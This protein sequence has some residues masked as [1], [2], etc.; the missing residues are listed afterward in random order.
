MEILTSHHDV[1]DDLRGG[2]LAIGNFDGVHRGHQAVLA[3]ALDA[4]K[5]AGVPAGVMSF[6]PHPLQV[7]R[8]D[9][10]L[11]RLTNTVQKTRLFAA[12]GLDI[13]AI[14]PFDKALYGLPGKDFIQDILVS[15]FGISH[16]V[17]GYDFHFGK[18]RDGN[19]D[20]LRAEGE[21]LG[22]NVTIVEP[23]ADNGEVFSSSRVREALR[24]G[25][26]AKAAD[27]LGYWWCVDGKVM[28]GAGR[29]DGMGY[30]TANIEL[31]SGQDLRHGIYAVRIASGEAIYYGAAYLGTRPTFDDGVPLLETFIFDFSSRI[32]GETLTV[33]FI[34]HIRDDE[35][36]SDAE[37]LTRQMAEDCAKCE[38]VL[39]NLDGR[40]D[41][42]L[43][44]LAGVL[45][46][47]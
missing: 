25:D 13:A 12:C 17:T 24:R 46:P 2:V 32:Y 15:G 22:F 16:A 9:P 6:E 38:T 3:V 11:F 26:V 44:P 7:F 28:P 39:Q 1:P 31:Q 21:R 20:V 30:P 27:I 40:S 29:G 19:P 36:F 14:L 10:P 47:A 41:P 4:G 35:K 8:P 42:E 5:K 43:R 37:A 18:G 23:V 34:E 45:M 33:E